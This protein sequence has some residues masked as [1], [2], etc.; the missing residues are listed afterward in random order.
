[1]AVLPDSGVLDSAGAPDA[2][3][4]LDVRC[5]VV[6]VNAEFTRLVGIDATTAV[7][8]QIAD[9]VTPRDPDGTPRCGWPR[10]A[11]LPSARAM[12]PV[13]LDVTH[14]SGRT[15][16][17]LAAARYVRHGD[18]LVGGVLSLRNVGRRRLESTAAQAVATASHELRAP[19]TGVH[20]FASLLLSRGD[21]LPA[22]QRREILE[23][24]VSDAE[25]MSR[26]VA[27]LLDVSR[28]EAGRVTYRPESVD[29]ADACVAAVGRHA[30]SVMVPDGTLVHA[31]RDKL[32]R[33]VSN[34]VENAVTHG[35]G[36]VA[37]MA[38][39]R[40]DV[41]AI[42]VT[43]AGS[44]PAGMLERV[45]AKFWRGDSSTR[46]GGTGLGLYLARALATGMDGSLVVASDPATGTTFTLTLPSE[47][48]PALPPAGVVDRVL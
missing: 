15:I 45:F 38:D 35:E 11:G 29:V 27:D 33:I 34:L 14:A 23:A 26:L 44:I 19:M 37:V 48:R 43:D 30:V 20:G 8:A 1:M 21:E 9:L 6:G 13:E 36:S 40:G 3:V 28:L 2:L 12:P 42:E 25:R 17:T 10:S 31:D 46:H 7:G 4:S 41:V 16:E 32:V 24:I 47:R 18:E 22:G 39:V 5:R